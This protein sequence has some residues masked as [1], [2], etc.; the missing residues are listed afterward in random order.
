MRKRTSKECK[1]TFIQK[2]ALF[3]FLKKLNQLRS[4]ILSVARGKE[5]GNLSSER[6]DRMGS[7]IPQIFTLF[8]IPKKLPS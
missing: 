7:K 1:L 8:S 4:H 2:L 5:G 6:E 3:L